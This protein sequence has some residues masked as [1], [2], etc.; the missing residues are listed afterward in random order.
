MTSEGTTKGGPLYMCHRHSAAGQTGRQACGVLLQ[1][2]QQPGCLLYTNRPDASPQTARP[3][4]R[5]GGKSRDLRRQAGEGW[6]EVG[7]ER[8]GQAQHRAGLAVSM[9]RLGGAWAT[10]EQ[11]SLASDLLSSAAWPAGCPVLLSCSGDT[12]T[13][14]HWTWTCHMATVTRC[15]I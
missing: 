15:T 11:G 3:W 2:A 13:S 14:V 9:T 7:P 5:P 10:L 8:P 6:G 4:G 12:P 1:G